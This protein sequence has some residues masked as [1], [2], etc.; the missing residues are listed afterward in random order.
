MHMCNQP[1]KDARVNQQLMMRGA[2]AP[3]NPI[4]RT[5]LLRSVVAVFFFYLF[6]LSLYLF[7]EVENACMV[8]VS[9]PECI[10]S[11]CYIRQS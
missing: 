4:C 6:I 2:D 10:N 9:S 5:H 11:T 8:I 1:I 3:K 7:I